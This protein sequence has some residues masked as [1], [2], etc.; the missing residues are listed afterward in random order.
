MITNQMVWC[1]WKTKDASVTMLS[2]PEDLTSL[3]LRKSINAITV[4][5]TSS[6]DHRVYEKE[7]EKID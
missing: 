6:W 1:T 2:R 3:L 5:I 4:D 7:V